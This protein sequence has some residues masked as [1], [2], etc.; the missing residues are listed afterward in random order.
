[1]KYSQYICKKN[2]FLW[3]LNRKNP[4]KFFPPIRLHGPSHE[5]HISP[6]FMTM[7]VLQGSR[8]PCVFLWHFITVLP[9]SCVK[10]MLK[11]QDPSPVC[12]VAIVWYK[13]FRHRQCHII[14]MSSKILSSVKNSWYAPFVTSDHHIWV[15]WQTS[16]QDMHVGIVN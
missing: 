10:N 16:K 6:V 2:F 11:L 5:K 7:R 9:K 4:F 3:T 14:I 8:R 13:T 15:L 1:M 12:H